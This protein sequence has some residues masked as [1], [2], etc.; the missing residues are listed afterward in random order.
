[1]FTH[2]IHFFQPESMESFDDQKWIFEI[3]LEKDHTGLGLTVAGY[4][5]EKGNREVII[6][7]SLM[8]KLIRYRKPLW[9]L[10][11]ESGGRKRSRQTGEN[12]CKRPSY[13]GD[14][15]SLIINPEE[16]I[17]EL[18]FQINSIPYPDPERSTLLN[19]SKNE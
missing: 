3:E 8:F 6:N 16:F 2:F 17:S 12:S 10:C 15:S 4:I 13:R 7:K 11:E 1:M 9:N 19:G 5:C 18:T 14:F